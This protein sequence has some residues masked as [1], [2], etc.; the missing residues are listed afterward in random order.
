MVLFGI[1]FCY[2][3]P[4]VLNSYVTI[5]WGFGVN[6]FTTAVS[7]LTAP[8]NDEFSVQKHLSLTAVINTTR[9]ISLVISDFFESCQAAAYG[10]GDRRQR[11][12][13]SKLRA[14]SLTLEPSIPIGGGRRRGGEGGGVRRGREDGKR[15]VRGRRGGR[16]GEEKEREGEG[17][18]MIAEEEVVWFCVWFLYIASAKLGDL[19]L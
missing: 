3:V 11:N 10:R 5:F 17:D 9:D 7:A 13:V 15:G 6:R 19:R 1:T 12:T 4:Q 18:V 2:P 16:G 14:S 8:I